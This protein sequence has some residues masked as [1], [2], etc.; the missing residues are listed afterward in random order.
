MK[1]ILGF[2]FFSGA[3]DALVNMPLPA[4]S[5][6]SAFVSGGSSPRGEVVRWNDTQTFGFIDVTD[7]FP[8]RLC[9]FLFPLATDESTHF[10]P[11]RGGIAL[12]KLFLSW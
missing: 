1:G 2:Q 11:A 8:Q 3:N 10:P 12:V 4:S 6:M 9:Q 7:F 5:Q